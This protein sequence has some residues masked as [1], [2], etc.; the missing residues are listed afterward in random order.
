MSIT[1]DGLISGGK[2]INTGGFFLS[3]EAR[4]SRR[5][6]TWEIIILCIGTLLVV[7]ATVSLFLPYAG[8]VTAETGYSNDNDRISTAVVNYLLGFYNIYYAL[9][10]KNVTQKY[11]K[12]I[13]KAWVPILLGVIVLAFNPFLDPQSMKYEDWTKERYGIVGI[14]KNLE[15]GARIVYPAEGGEKVAKVKKIDQLYFLYDVETDKELPRK[16]DTIYVMT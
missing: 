9:S 12:I 14:E 11:R 7:M 3:K 1:Q 6:S 8:T 10:T 4:K 13:G 16:G 2:V 15:D 5:L